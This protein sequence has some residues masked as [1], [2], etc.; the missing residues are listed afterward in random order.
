MAKGVPLAGGLRVRIWLNL[1]NRGVG[2]VSGLGDLLGGVPNWQEGERE[3][4][5]AEVAKI[6]QRCGGGNV[7]EKKRERG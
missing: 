5:N 3:E 7:N 1:G 2:A 6:T 4:F